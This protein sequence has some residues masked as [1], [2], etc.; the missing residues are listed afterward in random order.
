VSTETEPETRTEAEAGARQAPHG[1][2]A[3]R[4]AAI[5]CVDDEPAV[6][7]A[8]ARDLRRRFGE[9][10]RVMRAGSGADALELLEELRRRGDHVALIVSDQRM[11]AMSGTDFL[12]RARAIY[13]EAR[14]ALLT[15]YSDTA[16]AIAAINEAGLDYYLLKPWD[17]PE[18]GLYPVVG[19]LLEIWE[20]KAE[21]HQRGGVRILGHRFSAPTHDLRDFIAR[22][23]VPGRW[24][25]IE[26]D[27]EA[28]DLLAACGMGEDCLPVVVLEDGTPLK[29]P[30][31]SDLA[32]RLG[33]SVAPSTDHY[34]LVIVGGGPAGLA[35]AVYGASEGLRT[36]MV[37]SEAPGGQAGQSSR[38][39]N[40]LGFP[41]GLSGSDLARRA[42]TQARRL[43]AELLTVSKATALRV[44]G[45]GRIVELTGGA[46][47]SANSVIIS[48]GVSYRMMQAPGFS[49]LTGAG[50]YYGAAMTE[51][52]A[53]ADQ[54]VVVIGGAN[55]AGQ[56]A[57]YFSNFAHRVSM[58]VR[59]DSLA[60]SMSHYLIEQ[61]EKT[62]NIEVRTRSEAIAAEGEDGHLARLVIRGSDG[63][64]TT[65]QVDACFVFIG[66]APRTDWLDG[67]I[68][69]DEKGFILAGLDAREQGWPLSRPP[70]TLETSVPGVFV[71]GDV[72]A[73]SIKRVASAVG[74]GSM[75]VSLIHQYLADG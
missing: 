45:A 52:R 40:Y 66:A 57:M 30:S 14:R 54:H 3:T 16:A 46:Q 63:T 73:R 19:D 38:I 60:K 71:A 9:R 23:R 6:L 2:R 72:R 50:V 51:A 27:R 18:E 69:R 53:C 56:A 58:V 33:V 22:N 43:G 62:P 48:S 55:S 5:L 75:A 47:L 31:V 70:H 29:Q 67:V 68:A 10:Y 61:I 64:E 74:E 21:L 15:A 25:D 44:E 35:A 28:R 7:A 4:L 37:E 49:D 26:G 1:E 32:R 65:E 39:E 13:P 17:P 59:A 11:P 8:V 20:G 42:T 41:S 34:D 12:T 36:V 24:L